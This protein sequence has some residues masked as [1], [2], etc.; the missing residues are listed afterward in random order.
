MR[1]EKV[2]GRGETKAPKWDANYR[3]QSKKRKQKTKQKTTQQFVFVVAVVLRLKIKKRWTGPL[4]GCC[5]SAS[6]YG[7]LSCCFGPTSQLDT[8]KPSENGFGF[9][10]SNTIW[11]QQ[12]YYE[13][14][15]KSKGQLFFAA[16]WSHR[17]SS[18]FTGQPPNQTLVPKGIHRPSG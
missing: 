4:K 12:N 3:P 18:C 10:I 14:F 17:T 1:E 11:E 2:R 15:N 7:S 9:G 8:A 16:D 13:E 6:W 5:L